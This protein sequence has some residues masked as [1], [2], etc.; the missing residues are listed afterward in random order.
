M[1]GIEDMEEADIMQYFQE[2]LPTC[3]EWIDDVSCMF[4]HYTT[5]GHGCPESIICIIGVIGA[6]KETFGLMNI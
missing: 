2:F 6:H 1:R 5:F 3:V 4:N